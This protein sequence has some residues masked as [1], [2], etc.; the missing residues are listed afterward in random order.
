MA[1]RRRT[2][3][4]PV[5]FWITGVAV[6]LALGT[7][8]LGRMDWKAAIIAEARTKIEADP[9]AI[10]NQV[11]PVRDRLLHVAAVGYLERRELHMISSMKAFGP[12]FRVIT[13]MDLARDG[14]RTGRRI[15]VDLGFVPERMKSLTDREPTSIRLQKRHPTDRVVGLLYWPDETDGWTPEPDR[16]RNIWFARDVATMAVELGAEPVMLVAQSHPDGNI[17]LPQPPGIDIPN[18]HLEYVLTWYGLAA[19]WTAMS[20]IWLRARLRTRGG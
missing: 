15:L 18:R 7:W 19:V 1:G 20:L 16:E 9:V 8:Q 5:V 4:F 2:W 3:I 13:T 17:P 14:E 12:G 6:F 11:D 10:P